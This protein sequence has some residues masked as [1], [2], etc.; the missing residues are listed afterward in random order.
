MRSGGARERR[1]AHYTLGR[2][3]SAFLLGR[4]VITSR[5]RRHMA[6]HEWT[7]RDLIDCVV[8]LSSADFHKSQA[9]RSHEG[10]WLDIYR[11]VVAGERRYLKFARELSGSR[12]VLLSFCVDGEDH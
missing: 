4:F 7:E 3:Q 12:F 5:V 11:P 8:A 9:H 1:E 2:V 10:V 6:V